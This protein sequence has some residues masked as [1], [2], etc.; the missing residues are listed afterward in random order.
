MEDAIIRFEGVTKRYENTLALDGLNVNIYRGEFITTVG[1][2][3]GGK[4]TLVKLINGLLEPDE[5]RVLVNGQDVARVDRIQLRR[6]IG[7]TIQSVALFPHMS[8]AKNIAY[9]PS[10]SKMWDKPTERRRVGELLEV[11]GLEAAMARRYPAELSGGQ[12]QRVGIA[13][14]LAAQ[15]EILLMDEPFGAVDE[16]TRRSLQDEIVHIQQRLGVTIVFVTHDIKEALKLGHRV[17][18]VNEGKIAQLAT[19]DVMR[20]APANEFVAQLIGN[21]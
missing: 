3:G 15:P 16:I 7:Y 2:S 11:V 20:R 14:A 4:T 9:V 10:L 17:L 5:G 19:P 18:V 1:S 12:R 6:H 13:R 21:A 8:V